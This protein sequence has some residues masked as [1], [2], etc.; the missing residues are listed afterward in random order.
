MTSKWATLGGG[1]IALPTF[2]G[3]KCWFC[4]GIPSLPNT[5]WEGVLGSSLEFKMTTLRSGKPIN[6]Y[7]GG[8]FDLQLCASI[9]W[10][11][12]NRRGYFETWYRTIQM[13]CFDFIGNLGGDEVEFGWCHKYLVVSFYRGTA[14]LASTVG[15]HHRSFY[16]GSFREI[17]NTSAIQNNCFYGIFCGTFF[18]IL[19]C[20]ACQKVLT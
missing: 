19:S 10:E 17:R 4:W 8:P 15:N 5:S 11:P 1:W 7:K 12:W 16:R 13:W 2:S 6:L 9:G 14:T 3:A 20:P 18:V